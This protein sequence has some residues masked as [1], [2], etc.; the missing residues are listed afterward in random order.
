MLG[1]TSPL[2]AQQ[3]S[4]VWT[5]NIALFLAADSRQMCT[6]KARANVIKSVAMAFRYN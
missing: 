4:L 5:T 2:F 6:R 1:L 3:P